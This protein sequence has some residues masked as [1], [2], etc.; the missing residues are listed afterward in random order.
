L[1]VLAPPRPATPAPGTRVAAPRRRIGPRGELAVL[2]VLLLGGIALRVALAG[3]SLWIDELITVLKA[4]ES[5]P[6]LFGGLADDVHPPLYYVLLHQWIGLFGTSPLALRS[7]SIAWSAVTVLAAWAWSREAL[8]RRSALPAATFAALSPFAVWYATEVRMYA[9]VL[10][11]TAVAGWL[12]YRVLARGPR[13]L[14]L[15]GLGVCLGAL[16]WTHYLA[17]LFLGALAAVALALLAWRPPARRAAAWVIALCVVALASL[18]PWLAYVAAHRSPTSPDP[19]HY[20]V[21]NFYSVVIADAQMFAGFLPFDVLGRL[22]ALWPL[23]CLLAIGL[24]PRMRRVGWPVGGLVALAALPAAALVAASVLGPRS[25]FDP[26]FL[27]VCAV[28]LYLLAGAL[29]SLLPRAALACVVALLA[30]AGAAGAVWQNTSPA[31]PKLY[32]YEGAL[33]GINALARP[34]DA[35]LLLPNFSAA[36][37]DGEP[38]YDYYPL[39]RGVRA[40]ETGRVVQRSP[41]GTR[42]NLVAVWQDVRRARPPRVFVIDDFADNPRGRAAARVAHA[43][44]AA[45]ATRLAR[46]PYAHASVEIYRPSWSRR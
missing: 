41:A 22:S 7:L 19:T 3:R 11:L 32:D 10:A 15:L 25:A 36:G 20:P 43:V 40:I 23:G 6:T 1:A 46:L 27:A 29:L 35:V 38:V 45:R 18:A 17:S 24:L 4:R 33:R 21:P 5:L 12:A 14:D 8:P 42:R 26:R 31:N 37:V 9:Q 13:R 16:V 2:V 44:L 28:P 30:C 39:K 34:G